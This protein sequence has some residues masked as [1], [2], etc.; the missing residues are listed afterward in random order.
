MNY[1]AYRV[2]HAFIRLLEAFEF[3]KE[4][5]GD[6][7]GGGFGGGGGGGGGALKLGGRGGGNFN[8]ARAVLAAILAGFFVFFAYMSV[9]KYLL[10]HICKFKK[11][12]QFIR[13]RQMVLI[14]REL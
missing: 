9:E 14:I 7:M 5:D 2:G 11:P 13:V 6:K 4:V 8:S 3:V 1:T 10:K 12:F